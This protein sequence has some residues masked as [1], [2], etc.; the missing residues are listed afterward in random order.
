MYSK[1]NLESNVS[2]IFQV[3]RAIG[4]FGV[5]ISI[6]V[7][8]FVAFLIPY[9]YVQVTYVHICLRLIFVILHFVTYFV[10]TLVVYLGHLFL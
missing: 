3:R 1:N 10:D 4:D 2:Y 6:I 5:P 7:M 8:A 9:T